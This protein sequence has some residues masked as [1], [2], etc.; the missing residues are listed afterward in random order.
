MLLQSQFTRGCCRR[1][2]AASQQSARP[3]APYCNTW[4]DS[5]QAKL[6]MARLALSTAHPGRGSQI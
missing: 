1:C 6:D 4:L 2:H 5:Q 3:A